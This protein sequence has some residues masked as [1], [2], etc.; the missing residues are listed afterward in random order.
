MAANTDFATIPPCQ[1]LHVRQGSRY[2]EP[3]V[4]K[5]EGGV[6]ISDLLEMGNEV[7]KR[8]FPVSITPYY[9]LVLC[10]YTFLL[11]FKEEMPEK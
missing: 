1:Q 2:S 5:I 4:L 9:H 6:K 3:K 8:V 11:I 10:D 7:M